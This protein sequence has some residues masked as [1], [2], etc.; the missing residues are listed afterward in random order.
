MTV[1]ETFAAFMKT[2]FPDA[3]PNQRDCLEM[4]FHAGAQ[5]MYS[6]NTEI[7]V[8]ISEDSAIQLLQRLEA[9]LQ[10]FAKRMRAEALEEQGPCN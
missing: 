1:K 9:E 8:N 4:A 3:T 10:A 6:V 2:C 5:F 7:V